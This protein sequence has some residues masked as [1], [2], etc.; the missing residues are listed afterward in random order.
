[1]KTN[2]QQHRLSAKSQL[3]KWTTK[4]IAWQHIIYTYIHLYI[5]PLTRIDEGKSALSQYN[6]QTWRTIR[7]K[8]MAKWYQFPPICI[9]RPP[10]KNLGK[11]RIPLKF[12]YPIL[13][14][15]SWSWVKSRGNGDKHLQV[16]LIYWQFRFASCVFC[17]LTVF[18][19]TSLLI[20]YSIHYKNASSPAPSNA[21]L[22]VLMKQYI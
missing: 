14:C 20:N 1:M 21:P 19:F 7:R 8:Q 9:S 10:T 2:M 3:R 17:W 13:R 22:L 15:S 18:T 12:P 16:L 6:S 4:L 5:S 11:I